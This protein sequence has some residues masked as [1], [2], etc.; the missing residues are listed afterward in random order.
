MSDD[1]NVVS[2]PKG[3][4]GSFGDGG[5]LS[6]GGGGG[7]F[8]GMETRVKALE[9]DI[10]EIKRD[11]RALLIDSAEIKGTLKSMPS[12]ATMGE[13]KGRVDTLPTM[14]KIGSAVGLATAVI[15][16]LNNW[17]LIKTWIVG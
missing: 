1:T 17:S 14:A 2:F 13:L 10:K 5:G 3:E 8:D 12:A 6:S 11:L 16:I 9:D 15:V 7:T 4:R